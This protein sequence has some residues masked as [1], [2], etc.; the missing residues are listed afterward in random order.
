MSEEKI[1]ELDKNLA[2]I[3]AKFSTLETEIKTIRAGQS[4]LVF[5]VIGSLIATVV[6]LLT[7]GGL[8]G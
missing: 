8:A 4:R 7:S 1:A 3:T 5:V 6:N 2:V